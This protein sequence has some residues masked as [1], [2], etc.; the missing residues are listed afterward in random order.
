M[1]CD[2]SGHHIL[3]REQVHHHVERFLGGLDLLEHGL[4]TSFRLHVEAA[5]LDRF[6]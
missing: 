1:L 4:D 6:P 2:D 5:H 3:V